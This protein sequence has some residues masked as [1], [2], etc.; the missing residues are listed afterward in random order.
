MLKL[1]EVCM[2][3]MGGGVVNDMHAV[4]VVLKLKI[5]HVYVQMQL[6]LSLVPR[7]LVGG[8]KEPGMHCLRM[9]LITSN[10]QGSGYF[11]CTS[12][13]VDVIDG[14]IMHRSCYITCMPMPPRPYQN[15][16]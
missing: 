3:L 11:L 16:E 4:H 12:V 7:L 13:Y 14:R 9:R 10:F 5:V 6:L 15:C 1:L 2:T 8:E